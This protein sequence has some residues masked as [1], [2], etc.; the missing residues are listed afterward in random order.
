M[1]TF[2]GVVLM[3]LQLLGR[4]CYGTSHRSL[5]SLSIGN[6]KARYCLFPGL[7]YPA[8]PILFGSRDLL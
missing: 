4:V 6:F 3:S 2:L 1:D 8:L 7:N 5:T